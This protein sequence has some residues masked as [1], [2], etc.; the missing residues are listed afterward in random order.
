[1]VTVYG[2]DGRLA[3]IHDV[4][5]YVDSLVVLFMADPEV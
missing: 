2:S 5:H 3:G 4:L 1:M